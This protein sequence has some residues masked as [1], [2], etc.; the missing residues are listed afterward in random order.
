M[1]AG[2]TKSGSP[3]PS[4]MTFFIVAAMSKNRRMPDGGTDCTRRATKLRITSLSG[5][6]DERRRLA[7]VLRLSSFV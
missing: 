1:G 7:F 2:V 6:G 4:E 3:M 5:S